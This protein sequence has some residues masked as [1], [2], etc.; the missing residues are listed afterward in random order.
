MPH[1]PAVIELQVHKIDQLF[2]TLDP[3]PFQVRDLDRRAEDYSPAI[4][5]QIMQNNPT[6]TAIP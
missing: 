4:T 1:K 6:S 2:D 5:K 3:T